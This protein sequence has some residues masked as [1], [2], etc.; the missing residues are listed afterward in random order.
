MCSCLG[1]PSYQIFFFL[2]FYLK[3]WI[4]AQ[5]ERS[6]KAMAILR[7][8]SL[9]SRIKK[10]NASICS[11]NGP[12][13]T[14]LYLVLELEVALLQVLICMFLAIWSQHGWAGIS[15]HH[16]HHSKMICWMK[17]LNNGSWL[18]RDHYL[19]YSMN[20]LVLNASWPK[21]PWLCRYLVFLWY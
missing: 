2:P 17:V 16:W 6:A 18:Y 13:T 21:K 5:K 9:G 19:P 11:Q 3:L 1:R 10:K 15:G 4:F 8:L 7:G 20:T 12:N 14:N